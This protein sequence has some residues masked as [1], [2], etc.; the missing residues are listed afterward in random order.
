MKIEYYLFK[1]TRV[2]S[3][4]DDLKIL[5]DINAITYKGTKRTGGYEVTKKLFIG[6]MVISV[7]L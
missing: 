1:R 2:A 7:I 4:L 6:L 3:G 5:K